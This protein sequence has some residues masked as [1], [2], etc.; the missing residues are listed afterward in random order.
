MINEE[1]HYRDIGGI[2]SMNCS[3]WKSTPLIKVDNKRQVTLY[4]VCKDHL[5]MKEGKFPVYV[6]AGMCN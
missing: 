3:Q 4:M 5:K 6:Y 1:N 2:T